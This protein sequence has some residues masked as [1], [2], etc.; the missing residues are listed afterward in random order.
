MLSNRLDDIL[1][2]GVRGV[3]PVPGE[4]PKGNRRDV[5]GCRSRDTKRRNICNHEIRILMAEKCA[6][7]SRANVE[8]PHEGPHLLD[9]FVH[10]KVQTI[11]LRDAGIRFEMVVFDRLTHSEIEKPL[12]RI[13]PDDDPKIG[14]PLTERVDDFDISRRVPESVSGDVKDDGAQ[15]GCFT[16]VLDEGS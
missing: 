7:G 13:G 6:L 11:D 2:S 15:L 4:I 12:R 10:V 3:D 14:P 16:K 1:G 5:R 8:R 9:G